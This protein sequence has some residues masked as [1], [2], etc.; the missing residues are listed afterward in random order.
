MT[1][2]VFQLKISAVGSRG[3]FFRRILVPSSLDFIDLHDAIQTLMDW[4]DDKF[5]LFQYGQAQITDAE[6]WEDSS[7][8]E[9][10]YDAY[11]CNL[12]E[13]L[14]AGSE[15]SY[16]YFNGAGEWQLL[17]EVENEQDE[18]PEQ[19]YPRCIEAV[20]GQLLEECKNMEDYYRVL[21]IFKNLEHEEHEDIIEW[22]GDDF[23]PDLFDMDSINQ[24]LANVGDY[25]S[26]F[27]LAVEEGDDDF[28]AFDSLLEVPHIASNEL[29]LESARQQFE[30]YKALGEKAMAQVPDEGLFWQFN[31]DS[32]SIAIIV[33]HL[34]GNMLSRWTDFLTTD[35]EKEWRE[36]DSEFE[37]EFKTR[38]EMMDKWE[39]GWACLFETLDEL[40]GPDWDKTIYIRKEPHLVWQAIN[41]Q[42]AHYAYH[43][44]Q[45]VFLA[46]MLAQG[47]D[48]LSI[49]KGK[50]AEFNQKI[51][52]N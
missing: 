21:S 41:R 15:L 46:K 33:K 36:R 35:G 30:Q 50:S 27:E 9:D 5:F 23:D 25:E 17:I 8:Y 39:L 49:P 22:L 13:L 43:I 32:N 29:Q 47:W 20:G 40:T 18:N 19:E 51:N 6:Q 10:A 45:I 42:I 2:E 28:I 44:G 7:D 26:P 14:Q 3:P 24:E 34:W 12:A 1:K 48:S 16:R 11:S 52:L 31:D 4:G 37:I 38:N